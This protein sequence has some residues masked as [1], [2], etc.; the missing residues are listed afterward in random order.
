[1]LPVVELRLKRNGHELRE[2]RTDAT[3][4]VGVAARKTREPSKARHRL[5]WAGLRRGVNLLRS[6]H[7]V[8]QAATPLSAGQMD[9]NSCSRYGMSIEQR[10]SESHGKHK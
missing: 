5:L 7:R 9:A 1:M 8:A 10:V 6:E 3:T 2:T 4:L